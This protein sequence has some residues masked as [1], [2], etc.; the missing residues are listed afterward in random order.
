MKT[1]F[2]TIQDLVENLWPKE[3]NTGNWGCQMIGPD[4]GITD[5]ENNIKQQH[6]TGITVQTE[7]RS[8]VIWKTEV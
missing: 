4:D 5:T 1:N 3:F 6:T 8:Y 2:S 7:R